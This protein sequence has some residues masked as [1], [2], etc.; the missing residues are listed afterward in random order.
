MFKFKIKGKLNYFLQSFGLKGLVAV[1]SYPLITL[2]VTPIRLIQTIWNCRV[3]A[4]G[5]NWKN[6]PHFSSFMSL[7]NLFYWSR[8]MNLYRFGRTGISPYMGN[9][10]YKQTRCFHYS[11]IS[12]YCYWKAGAVTLLVGMFGWLIGHLIWFDIPD[13]NKSWLAATIFLGID[14][15]DVLFPDFFP[16]KL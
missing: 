7:N 16:T 3:L 4:E 13:L 14:K 9:G 5:K 10:D 1:L 15:H 8:A 6:Y 12:L 11:L 2:M